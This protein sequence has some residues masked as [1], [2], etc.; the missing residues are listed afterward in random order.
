MSA[1]RFTALTALL[2]FAACDGEDPDF[3]DGGDPSGGGDAA[4]SM[5]GAPTGSC[6]HPEGLLCEDYGGAYPDDEARTSCEDAFYVWSDSPCDTTNTVGGCRIESP[7]GVGG[8]GWWCVTSWQFSP[9]TTEQVMQTCPGFYV[10][11]PS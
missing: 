1:L 11:P 9:T 5:C 6:R 10:P 8:T 7:S 4:A 2:A 3:P